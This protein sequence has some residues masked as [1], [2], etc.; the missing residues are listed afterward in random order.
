M[1]T[2]ILTLFF[3]KRED[4][5]LWRAVK[6]GFSDVMRSIFL[7][8]KVAPEDELEMEEVDVTGA[9]TEGNHRNPGNW[10]LAVWK[11]VHLSDS[12]NLVAS[13][14]VGD[15]WLGYWSSL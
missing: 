11:F 15:M 14:H 13:V 8:Q 1:A 2:V 7:Q 4:Y 5:K 9:T 12:D 10:I 6:E 3:F